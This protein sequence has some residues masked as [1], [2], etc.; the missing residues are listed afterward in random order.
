MFGKAWKIGRIG[1]IDIRVDASWAFL[2]IFI[3]Y[4]WWVA[5]TS[6]PLDIASGTALALG[7]LA[8]LLF[9]G[10]ILAHELA[11]AAMARARGLPVSG[12]RLFLF[13]GATGVE[14]RG[15]AD[16]FLV[17]AVGP[18]TSLAVGV[19]YIG[20]SRL[21]VVNVPLAGALDY[22][23]RLNL[24]LALLNALPGFPLDG[25]RVLRAIAWK[26]TG[27][28]ARATSIAA[29]VGM[30]VAVGLVVF[31]LWQVSRANDDVYGI[32]FVFIGFFVFQGARSAEQQGRLRSLL[33]TGSVGDAMRAPAEAIP[34]GLSLSEAYDRFLRGH[35]EETFPVA[36]GDRIVGMLDFGSARRV[37]GEDPLRPVRD[38]M[39]PVEEGRTVRADE[40]LDRVLE[41]VIGGEVAV[42][43]DGELVG[44]L[45]VEDVDRWLRSRAAS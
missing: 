4:T 40:R 38:A 11:H 31:G 24:F 27:D 29:R 13:G 32:W 20:I 42:L 36:D 45:S 26:V 10:S 28:Q 6:P 41:R 25:G 2:A 15:P 37:G 22:L 16:E 9:F 44:T 1:G 7:V 30:V 19:L 12:I 14:E 3:V 33:R 5:F 35:E 8:A 34:A 17:T 21:D 43:R 39:L 18:L 23:G